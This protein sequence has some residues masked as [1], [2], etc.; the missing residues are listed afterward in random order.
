MTEE[1]GATASC[2]R[3]WS[4]ARSV[5]GADS[6]LGQKHPRKHSGSGGEGGEAGQEG[7]T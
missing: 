4:C 1:E 5:L 7:A 6:S 3:F 2:R